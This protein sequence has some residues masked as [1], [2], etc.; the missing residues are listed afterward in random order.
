MR[1]VRVILSV[2]L[3]S[4]GGAAVEQPLALASDFGWELNGTYA[5]VSNGEYAKSNDS[6]H[7]EPVVRATWRISSTCSSPSTCVGAVTS[8]QGWTAPM[9]FTVDRWILHRELADWAPC[10]A[11][12]AAVGHQTFTFY[13]LDDDGQVLKGSNLLGGFDRTFT[14]S[15]SCGKN[16]PLNIVI[17][18]R[19]QKIG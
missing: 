3:L 6:F 13:P 1:L 15:G 7:D 2:L 17:P 18:M 5:F 14:D 9:K 19:L 8:D 12:G 10:D 4:T 16:L 11:G